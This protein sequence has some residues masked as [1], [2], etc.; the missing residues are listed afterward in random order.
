MVEQSLITKIKDFVEKTEDEREK[1]Y[2]SSSTEDY[3][4]LTD[5]EFQSKKIMIETKLAVEKMK[6]TLFITIILITF[7]TGFTDKM[8]GFLKMISSNML[9][10]S[11]EKGLVYDGIFWLSILLYFIVL[12]VLLFIILISLKKYANLVREEKIINQVS[13]MRENRGEENRN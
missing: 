4:S 6:F 8:F 12:L 2:Y 9:S 10:V 1:L 3:L 5:E 13:G 7:L 11:A